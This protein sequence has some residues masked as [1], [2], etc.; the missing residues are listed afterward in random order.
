MRLESERACDD[1]VLLS[2]VA[3]PDYAAHL[4]AIVRTVS[5]TEVAPAMAQIGAMEARMRHI[6]DGTK[7]RH[8]QAGWL[9]ISAV[10][11]T[12]LLSLAALHVSARPTEAHPLPDRG[13]LTVKSDLSTSRPSQSADPANK[14]GTTERTDLP[15]DNA[16]P[17]VKWE[18]VSWGQAVDGLEPG[19]LPLARSEAKIWRVVANSQI[20]YRLF[21]RNR[22]RGER[23]FVVQCLDTD[24]WEIPYLIPGERV[25]GALKTSRIPDEFR[26]HWNSSPFLG[27]F[28]SFVITLGPGETVVVPGEFGLSLNDGHEETR[29]TTSPWVDAVTNGVNWL[30]HPITVRPLTPEMLAEAKRTPTQRVIVY[31]RRGQSLERSAPIVGA[32]KSGK[33]LYARIRVEVT[34]QH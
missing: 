5:T 13:A 21:V 32:M 16:S 19:L 15:K 27:L 12:A 9:T 1:R 26:A 3:G 20:K 10:F 30:L 25:S 34:T 18:N 33:Q 31:D 4:L 6:L 28:P 29:P 14:P 23:L 8:I 11:A 17:A 24:D 7:P 22:T 2:G